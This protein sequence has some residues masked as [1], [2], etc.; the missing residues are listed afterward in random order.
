[1]RGALDLLFESRREDGRY[2]LA[3][4]GT[5]Y[6]CYTA[7]TARVLCRFGFSKEE[8]VQRS[9]DYLL[10]DQSQDG[11][12]RCNMVA[13]GRDPDTDLSNPG[14]TMFVL[15]A[16]RFT[17]QLNR[18]PA[19]DRGV[20]TLLDH[21]RVRR[22]LGP[23]R[24]GIGTMFMQVEYPFLRYNV[25]A[26]VY[27]LSFYERARTDERFREALEVLRSKVDEDGNLVVERPNRKLAGLKAFAKGKPS[28]PATRRYR[29]ILENLGET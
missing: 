5:L 2:R 4:S 29:E 17:E 15:D 7:N 3:P 25:F 26:Y 6:P 23:C 12:W 18:N 8:R 16:F 1:M 19:L 20:K 21:W 9:L 14:V 24:F 10:E 27:I 13:F 28:E 11:G 22:P